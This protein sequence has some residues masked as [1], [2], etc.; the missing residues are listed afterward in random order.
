[1]KILSGYSW[2]GNVRELQ[3]VLHRILLL[4]KTDVI[5]QGDLLSDLST[6]RKDS[7]K[8][9]EDVEREHILKV[10]KEVAGHRGTAAEIL[11]I[12]TKTL[13]RKLLSYGV[14]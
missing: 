9:L 2:P 7:V 11:G 10:L 12:D 13:Y 8:R 3:N 5:E 6:E 1:M 4:S 14:K